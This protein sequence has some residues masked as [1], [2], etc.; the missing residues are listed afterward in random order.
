LIVGGLDAKGA[1]GAA[2]V[3][4][5]EIYD[6]AA[7]AFTNASDPSLGGNPGGYMAVQTA[8]AAI[9]VARVFHT[10]TLLQDGRVPIAGGFGTGNPNHRQNGGAVTFNGGSLFVGGLGIL[11]QPGQTS[12]SLYMIPGADYWDG[13]QW[14][15][16]PAPTTDRVYCN[17]QAIDGGDVVLA[18]GSDKS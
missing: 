17:V 3:I 5:N 18:C 15:Q 7:N 10:A 9:P 8:T 6:P 11:E 12:P 1:A 14:V 16:A 2:F 4:E 13:T